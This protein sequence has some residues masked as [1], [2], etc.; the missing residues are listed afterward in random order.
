[1]YVFESN[2]EELKY[3][4][5]KVLSKPRILIYGVGQYGITVAKIALR[6]GWPIVGAVN[7]AGKKIGRDLGKVLGLDMELGITLSLIHISEPTR[8]Y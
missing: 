7:R 8:P 4:R 5:S 3:N 2:M 6:K 1:M